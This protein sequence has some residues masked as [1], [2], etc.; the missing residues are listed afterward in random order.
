MNPSDGAISLEELAVPV[1]TLS[2]G[3]AW[4]T[5]IF[6]QL[7]TQTVRCGVSSRHFYVKR[8]PLLRSNSDVIQLLITLFR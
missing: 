1:G 2:A 8:A 6:C 5:D 4:S 3:S 7:L